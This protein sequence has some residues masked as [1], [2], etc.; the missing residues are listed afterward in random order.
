MA[1]N[2]APLW[3]CKAIAAVVEDGSN[4]GLIHSLIKYETEKDEN[5]IKMICSSSTM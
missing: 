4:S 5:K 1:T 2:N 3:F